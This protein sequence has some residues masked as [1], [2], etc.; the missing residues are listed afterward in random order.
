MTVSG[1]L[2]DMRGHKHNN[3]REDPAPS[4][5]VS[6]YCETI[7]LCGCHSPRSMTAGHHFHG[8]L[9]RDVEDSALW[10]LI[11]LNGPGIE[12][13]MLSKIILPIIHVWIESTRFRLCKNAFMGLL[14]NEYWIKIEM[15]KTD[16]YMCDYNIITNWFV[17][18]QLVLFVVLVFSKNWLQVFIED[19][20]TFVQIIMNYNAA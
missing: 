3:T 15:N 2:L 7:P 16:T 20:I 12:R 1:K 18:S 13:N 11:G 8:A 14:H 10:P 19:H 5:M 17:Y 9:V 4:Q 6:L